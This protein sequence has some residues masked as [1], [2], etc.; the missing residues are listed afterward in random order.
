LPIAL[1]MPFVGRTVHTTDSGRRQGM[2]GIVDRVSRQRIAA[3]A[4][5]IVCAAGFTLGGSGVAGA[6][7]AV[8]HL[9]RVHAS[10][11]WVHPGA[12]FTIAA[13]ARYSVPEEFAV[14]FY[15]DPAK[16]DLPDET[17]A[18]GYPPQP[19]DNPSCEYDNRFTN[20]TSTVGYFRIAP[21]ATG[22]F[23]V[24][25]CTE[26]VSFGGGPDSPG[27]RCRVRSFRVR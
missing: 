23:T 9:H 20:S 15:F 11:T 27:D 13:A 4:V 22:R 21:N 18:Q 8:P 10:A 17:C 6:A 3:A 14:S 25:V 19:G 24:T 2:Q 1:P 16:V 12:T 7:H 5:G 26:T